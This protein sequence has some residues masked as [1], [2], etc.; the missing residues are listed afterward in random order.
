MVRIGRTLQSFPPSKRRG[1]LSTHA[2]VQRDGLQPL[3]FTGTLP[4]PW[5]RLSL[6]RLPLVNIP[7]VRVSEAVSVHHAWRTCTLS[8]SLPRGVWRRRRLRPPPARTLACSCPPRGG[9][10]VWECPSARTRDASAPSRPP[11]RRV[12]KGTTRAAVRTRHAPHPPI[13]GLGGVSHVHPARVTT[14]PT[15]VSHVSLGHRTRT[16]RRVWRAGAALFW[17]RLRPP[18]GAT[19]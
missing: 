9:L 4:Q 17:E 18:G 2:A 16:V 6:R 5:G 1:R 8:P 3:C 7:H 11:R 13:L 14:L 19:P 10:A 15:A 12:H